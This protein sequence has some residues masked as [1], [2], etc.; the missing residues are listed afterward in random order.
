MSYC[1]PDGKFIFKNISFSISPKSKCAL[2]GAN[3]CGKSSLISM[4]AGKATSAEGDITLGNTPYIVPQHFGQYNELTVGEVLGISDKL[5]ALH[6]ILSG[7]YSEKDFEILGDD[8]TIE[9]NVRKALDSW[10]LTHIN[11]DMQLGSLSGGEKTKVFLA[12]IELHNPRILIMDEPTNHLDESSRKMLY[13]FID[14]FSGTLLAASHD[15]TLLKH[16]SSILE[17][18]DKGIR[19]YPMSFDEYRELA[20]NEKRALVENAECLKKELRKERNIARKVAERQQKQNSRGQRNSE[21]K[22]VAR[23]ALGNLKNQAENSTARLNGM[24]ND[25]IETLKGKIAE[26]ISEISEIGRMAVDLSSSDIHNGKI[27]IEAKSLN[28]TFTDKGYLWPENINLTIR[29]GDRIRVTGRN[30]SGKSSLMR[31][32][33]GD[34]A[35]ACGTIYRSDN[36]KCLYLDQEYSLIDNNAT[37]AQQIQRFNRNSLQE[38]ELN[39]R[40][41]RFLF[42][43]SCWD[44]L[45]KTLSGGE[46]MRLS[47][48]CLMVADNAPD[49]IIADEPTN[50]LDLFNMEVLTDTLYNYS[51]TLIIISHDSDFANQLS[52]TTH[53]DL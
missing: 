44:K 14:T 51:G 35:P 40:L 36:L 15:I 45:C 7:N 33:M 28:L 6:S 8:W 9:D 19:R 13:N 23:I 1:L 27:L 29:S 10:D 24:H 11:C 41:S 42:P 3:G 2:V 5:S 49:I 21:K 25:K 43:E 32:I 16:F 18:S 20:D 53:I 12:G 47:L 26:A 48:C 52:L 30:G 17:L 50:N 31:I 38:H 39:I 22:C 46:K 37:V 4:L 34:L